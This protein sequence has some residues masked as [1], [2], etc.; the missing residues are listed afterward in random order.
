[1]AAG[2]TIKFIGTVIDLLL[3]WILAYTIDSIVPNKSI[4]L[5]LL[6]GSVM[7]VCAVLAAAANIAANRMASAV[8]RDTT[9]AIRHDLFSKISY[10]SCRQVDSFTVPSLETRLTTDTYHLHQMISSMQRLGVRAPILLLGGIIVT[11]SLEPVLALI[12]I[13]TLPIIAAIIFLIS[14]KGVPLYKKLQTAVDSLVRTVRENITGIRVI[15]ALSK[16]EYEKE[17]FS[18]INEKVA[19]SEKKAGIT[20]AISN[21]GMNLIL[22]LG[23]TSVIVAGAFRVDSGIT[24]PGKI[25]AF[26]SYFTIILNAMH[27]ITRLFVMYTRGVASAERIS[28][29]LSAPDDLAVEPAEHKDSPYHIEF[30]H[31]TFTY[32]KGEENKPSV[33]DI[34]FK[35]KQGE[36]LGVIGATGSGKSTL[37]RLLMRMYDPDSGRIL[38]DG[39]DVRGIPKNEL[40]SKFGTTLQNDIL[41]SGTIA[42]NIDFGRGLSKE[43]LETTAERAQAKEFIQKLP[44]GFEHVL[45]PRSTNLSGGQKQRILIARALA[46]NPAILI[47]DDSSSALDYKTDS[48]IRKTLSEDFPETTKIIIAQ[49][50]SSV[51][52]ADKILVMDEGRTAGFGTH[53]E[54]LKSCEIYAEIFSL[55]MGGGEVG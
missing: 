50:V 12:L 28:E 52:N 45:T 55:Q 25:I 23:L 49:R 17:R 38:I 6:W 21:P 42:S 41:F 7:V 22:N 34:C 9:E 1:M 46:A 24:Q 37:I 32:Q 4:P 10:L 35:L 40:Y 47:L 13:I 16:T 53:E 11:L 15:K 19:E 39:E 29:V 18:G 43:Q 2:F 36:T 5:I 8:A 26:L 54:L 20:M 30:E 33:E 44:L 3:P 27:S 51:F 14:K 48:L 31:V